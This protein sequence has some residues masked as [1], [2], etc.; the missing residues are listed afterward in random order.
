MMVS[1]R[2]GVGGSAMSPLLALRSTGTLLC[3]ALG[4]LHCGLAAGDGGIR[5]VG[6]GLP[7]T[8]TQSLVVALEHLGYKSCHGVFF[9]LNTTMRRRWT[10]YTHEGGPLEPA[11]GMLLEQGYDVTLDIPT[12][13]AWK[14]L[15]DRYPDSKVILT[16][17]DSPERWYSS[18]AAKLHFPDG[19]ILAAMGYVAWYYSLDLDGF[20]EFLSQNQRKIGCDFRA[21]QTPELRK[22]CIDGY[23][24]HNAEVHRVIPSDRLLVFNLKEGWAP[25]CK[26]LGVP[27]PDIP[28]PM[29]D[30]TKGV[31]MDIFKDMMDEKL[32]MNFRPFLW[33]SPL[34]LAQWWCV[35]RLCRCCCRR[36]CGYCCRSMGGSASK[37]NKAA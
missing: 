28:F 15:A 23:V 9:W 1:V 31:T 7:C 2:R 3:L 29:R 17:R 18:F 26:F 24:T 33:F 13:Y 6:A 19:G 16:V 36:C 11:L 8:G 4:S 37:G 27:V 34:V 12:V 25:L 10:E 20:W 30:I 22:R 21:E 14:D 5:L 32:S 35:W